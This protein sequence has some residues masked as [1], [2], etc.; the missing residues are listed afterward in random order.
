MRYWLQEA[1]PLPKNQIQTPDETPLSS[2]F[3]I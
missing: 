3:F 1:V 2:G